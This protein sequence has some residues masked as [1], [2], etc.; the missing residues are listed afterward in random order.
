M[1]L[2]HDDLVHRHRFQHL[3]S[4]ASGLDHRHCYTWLAFKCFG[5]GASGNNANL[6]RGD[7]CALELLIRLLKQFGT[8]NDDGKLAVGARQD[9]MGKDMGLSRPCGQLN[10]LVGVSRESGLNEFKQFGLVRSEAWGV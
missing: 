9:S 8:V 1:A 4:L 6:P 5:P 3:C 7:S 10:D 2:I